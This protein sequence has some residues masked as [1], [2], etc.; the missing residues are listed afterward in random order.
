MYVAVAGEVVDR[1]SMYLRNLSGQLS[2]N[3]QLLE[4]FRCT[5]IAVLLK[6]EYPAQLFLRQ[7]RATWLQSKKYT[8][9][10]RQKNL[11]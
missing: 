6:R 11:R 10:C 4:N 5:C 2:G 3:S 7:S 8:H 9:R 1:R